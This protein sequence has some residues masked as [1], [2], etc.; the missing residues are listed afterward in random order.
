LYS[1]ADYAEYI[2]RGAVDVVRLIADNVGGMSGS[3][4]VGL[5]ADAFGLEC[6]PH[7]WG[8]VLD[9]AVHFHQELALPNAYWF[10]MPFPAE[11]ADRAYHKDTFRIDAEGYVTAPTQPGLGYPI[12]RDVLDKMIKRINR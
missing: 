5:L 7:N 12:D 4:R 11:W 3:M 10:E 9:L 1:I 8:N 2:R 6:T